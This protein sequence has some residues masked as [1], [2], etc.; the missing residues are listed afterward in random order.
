MKSLFLCLSLALV[1][2]SVFSTTTLA[3]TEVPKKEESVPVTAKNKKPSV[4]KV[5]KKTKDIKALPIAESKTAESSPG[6]NA[7]TNIK[8]KYISNIDQDLAIKS[9]VLLPVMDNLSGIYSKPIEEEIKRVLNNDK[10]WMLSELP[11]DMQVKM[12]LLDEN[13]GEVQ[14][15]LQ[16]TKSEAVLHCNLVKGPR[17]ISVNMTLFV[18]R[19]GLPFLQESFMEYKGFEIN[20]VKTQVTKLFDTLRA[21]MPFRG[22]ILSRRGQEVTLNLGSDYGLK[23]DSRVSAVQ[24]LKVHRHPKQKFLVSTE[25]EVLGRVKLFKVDRYLSFGYIEFEKEPGVISVGAKVMPDEFVKY[26]LPVLTPSGKVLQ[27][28]TQRPDKAVSFGE[29]PTEWVPDSRPQFGK[30]EFMGG[31]SLYSQS[32]QLVTAGSKSGSNSMAPNV[33]I[34]GEI[35][36]NPQIYMNLGLRQSIFSVD[37][38]PGSLPGNLTISMGQYFVGGGYNFLLT[39]QFFG[40]KM[41]VSASYVSTKFGVDE[42]T[43]TTFTSMSYTGFLIGFAGQFPVSDELPIDL[44]AKLDLYVNSS[45]SEDKTSGA[46]SNNQISGYSFYLDY[47]LRKRFKVRGELLFENY[48]SSFS[49]TGGRTDPA[50]SANHTMTTLMG[51]VQYLF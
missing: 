47:K 22:N 2:T 40:P 50:T 46:T 41:Q 5:T 13:P 8:N 10:Q 20:D 29:E 21:R 39:D 15:V 4:S 44:G 12:D 24:I 11:K 18:G 17:G 48:N 51:G 7:Q 34:R 16:A 42:S 37:N 26:A 35:W 6:S 36:M 3:E 31:L 25:K 45:L 27:D 28:I 23:E 14:K 38:S 43:P 32:V 1:G 33:A 9:I 30:L 49:G 19:E